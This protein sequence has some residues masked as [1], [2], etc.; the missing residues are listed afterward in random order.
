MTTRK[1]EPRKS[2]PRGHAFTAAN[3]YHHAK[4]GTRSCRICRKAASARFEQRGRE[5]RK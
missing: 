4:T 1:P 3:T 5:G 2:C